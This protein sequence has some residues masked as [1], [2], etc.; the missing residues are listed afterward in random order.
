MQNEDAL[1]KVK[2]LNFTVSDTAG[3]YEKLSIQKLQSNSH[4][5]FLT[6][7]CKFETNR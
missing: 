2:L 3:F 4:L 6:E 5:S 1:C 7:R